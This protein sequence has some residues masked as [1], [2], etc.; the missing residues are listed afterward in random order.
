MSDSQHSLL[1]WGP[2]Q[3]QLI[4]LSIVPMEEMCE[5]DHHKKTEL[6]AY[7]ASRLISRLA[8]LARRLAMTLAGRKV[9]LCCF[10][11]GLSPL[12]KAA[13]SCS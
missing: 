6:Q 7:P 12:P 9:L 4:V 5:G 3:T 1:L 10:V 2:K 8:I 11:G 13:A